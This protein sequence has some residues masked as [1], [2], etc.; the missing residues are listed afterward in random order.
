MGEFIKLAMRQNLKI[1]L[2][3]VEFIKQFSKNGFA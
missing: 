2:L 1:I 3:K